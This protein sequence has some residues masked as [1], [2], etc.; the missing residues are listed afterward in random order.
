[1]ISSEPCWQFLATYG[2]R[3][4]VSNFSH[5]IRRRPR[6]T[7]STHAM[8]S[9]R[10]TCLDSWGCSARLQREM[11]NWKTTNSNSRP[12]CCL[13]RRFSVLNFHRPQ[14]GFCQ[15]AELLIRQCTGLAL[16]LTATR[17]TITQACVT[18]WDWQP[19]KQP[20]QRAACHVGGNSLRSRYDVLLIA[21]VC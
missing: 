19:C 3:K 7:S 15:R 11:Y 10:R 4:V 12:Q 16:T 20:V 13:V 21:V 18:S 14:R 2:L 8:C 17:T 5:V 1:M 9:K 6:N